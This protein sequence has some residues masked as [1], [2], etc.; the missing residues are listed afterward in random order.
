M[1]KPQVK[2]NKI[3][4]KCVLWKPQKT[5][6]ENLK[7]LNK[8]KYILCSWIE[9][10]N[11]IM[12][13]TLPKLIYSFNTIPIRMSSYLFLKIDKL[14]LIRIW[15][16]KGPRILEYPKQS[17]KRKQNRKTHTSWFKNFP[18]TTIIMIMWYW[19]KDRQLRVVVVW[20]CVCLPKNIFLNLI[21]SCGCECILSRTIWWGYFR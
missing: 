6:K 10:F 7:A 8:W 4:A 2:F 18:E 12:M 15:Y 19:Y 5:L 14:I 9:K 1:K 20:R 17:W 3:G 16:W 21:H 11:I 13:V